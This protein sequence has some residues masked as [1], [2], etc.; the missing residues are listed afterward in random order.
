[1]KVV[2]EGEDSFFVGDDQCGYDEVNNK[3]QVLKCL[4]CHKINVI[5]YTSSSLWDYD[6]GD[7]TFSGDVSTIILYPSLNKE[8]P[9][10][11]RASNQVIELAIA[12]LEALILTS[13][14]I[15]GVDRI[16]TVLHAHL[17]LLC[18]HAGIPFSHDDG[19]TKLF[20]ILCQYH[21]KFQSDNPNSQAT[22]RLLKS[23]AG[24]ID[25]LNPI[26]NHA[27]LAHPNEHLLEKE[28]ASLFINVVRTLVQYLDEKLRI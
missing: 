10:D 15:G 4:I 7:E 8:K 14:L 11:L 13:R 1:M 24:I 12:D 16:H 22:D 18:A 9:L 6:I 5:Q 27:S 21:P 2:C 20:K 3:W 26:R 17:R 28:E 23:F 25:S 19:V